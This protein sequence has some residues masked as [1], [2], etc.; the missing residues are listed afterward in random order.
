MIV[1]VCG[2]IGSG[3]STLVKN[4]A[5]K[6]NFIE[7]QEP[8]ESN[9][10]LELYY[11]DPS[12]WSYAMQINLLFERYKQMQEAYFRSLRGENII[13]D[14]TIYSD[15]A[16]AMVQNLEHYFTKEEYKSYLNIY[17]VIN[18]HTVYPDI[19]IFLDLSTELALERIAKRSR[20]CESNIPIEYLQKL[21][22]AYQN[23]L[24]KLNNHTNI[25]YIDAKMNE[26]DVYNAVINI[27]N[28][29]K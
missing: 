26:N 29:H 1:S 4:I 13:V 18:S 19:L 20:D 9:P 16:F 5:N 21:L 7:F 2:L 27:I 15:S 22:V 23:V 8:V 25:V 17:E 11:K 6:N 24:S 3:K 14:S 12:R 10:F 28:K